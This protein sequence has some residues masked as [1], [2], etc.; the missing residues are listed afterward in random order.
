MRLAEERNER[1]SELPIHLSTQ[2]VE[3]VS[4]SRADGDLHVTVLVLT[5]QFLRRWEDARILVTELEEAFHAA[6]TVLRTLTV[7]AVWKVHDQT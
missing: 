1:L 4:R 5:I 6:R 7:V 2:D 3:A